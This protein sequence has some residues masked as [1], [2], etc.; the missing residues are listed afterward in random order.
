MQDKGWVKL[1]RELLDKPIWLN[2]T[3]EQKCVLNVLLLKA[4]H[5]QNNWEWKGKP[6]QCKAG[7]FITSYG[8][9]ANDCGK[10]VSRKNVITALKRFQNLEFLAYQSTH[11][12]DSGIKVIISNWEIYQGE[13]GR[14]SGTL[15]SDSSHTIDTLRATNKNEKND[16]NEKKTTTTEQTSENLTPI[17]EEKIAQ[18]YKIFGEYKNVYLTEDEYQQIICGCV[19]KDLADELIEELSEAIETGRET[20]H[21][22]RGNGHLARLRAFYK[23]RKHNKKSTNSKPKKK[24]IDEIFDEV[25][26]ER[27]SK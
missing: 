22:Q 3:P 24:S 20:L 18:G 19:S 9:I 12:W 6:Y 14:P 17:Q 8:N 13:T 15:S 7:E 27:E 25:L 11:G 10:G 23:W 16:K 1:Y 2:S 21:I 26:A 4:N 5:K